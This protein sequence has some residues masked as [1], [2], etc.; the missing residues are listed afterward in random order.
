MSSNRKRGWTV[1]NELHNKLLKSETFFFALLENS[2]LSMSVL[3]INPS[4]FFYFYLFSWSK[5]Q[6]TK[7]R[8]TGMVNRNRCQCLRGSGLSFL[9][10]IFL[11]FFLPQAKKN[12]VEIPVFSEF[13]VH[14]KHQRQP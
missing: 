14:L 9:R 13:A 1:P 4:L 10:Q 11:P 3:L 7:H 2:F 5:D 6:T 8:E 12:N